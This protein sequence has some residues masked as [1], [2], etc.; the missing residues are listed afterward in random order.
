[1]LGCEYP[2]PRT[3]ARLHLRRASRCVLAFGSDVLVCLLGSGRGDFYGED[4][5]SFAF[6]GDVGGGGGVGAGGFGAGYLQAV[7]AAGGQWGVWGEGSD[8]GGLAD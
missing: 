4:R 7:C 6:G 2:L 8:G 3:R 5:E 1:M